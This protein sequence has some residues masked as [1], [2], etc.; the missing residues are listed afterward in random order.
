MCFDKT[1]CEKEYAQEGLLRLSAPIFWARPVVVQFYEQSCC[2]YR[3]HCVKQIASFPER[4]YQEGGGLFLNLRS[5]PLQ[6]RRE[7]QSSVSI[8]HHLNSARGCPEK[9]ATNQTMARPATL[10]C[11]P[12]PP[13]SRRQISL[14]LAYLQVAAEVGVPAEEDHVRKELV[15][16]LLGPGLGENEHDGLDVQEGSAHAPI[17]GVGG[18][19]NRNGF[20]W[21]AEARG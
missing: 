13:S 3:F 8:V 7:L 18:D 10:E 9:K 20:R 16:P 1:K 12:I 5:F 19:A 6:I 14:S 21:T 11:I 4:E 15:H 17:E 2:G